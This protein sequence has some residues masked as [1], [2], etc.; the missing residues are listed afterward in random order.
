L[1][2]SPS[3]TPTAR[4]PVVRRERRRALSADEQQGCAAPRVRNGA[5][6]RP[7]RAWALGYVRRHVHT[8]VARSS[9][10][11]GPC[12]QQPMRPPHRSRA[13]PPAQGGHP[14]GAPSPPGR[15]R[16]A[17]VAPRCP[18]EVAERAAFGR[19]GTPPNCPRSSRWTRPLRSCASRL[20]PICSASQAA[21]ACGTCRLGR[22]TARQPCLLGPPLLAVGS[23]RRSTHWSIYPGGLWRTLEARRGSTSLGQRCGF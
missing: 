7:P 21:A 2:F 16:G 13:P 22:A 1:P 17:A 4:Q 14:S 12:S 15:R 3:P 5:A 8:V 11:T 20:R 9:G 19:P 6:G 10:R 18:P 23:G